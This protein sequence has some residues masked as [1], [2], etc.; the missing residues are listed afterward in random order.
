[1]KA[2]DIYQGTY[3]SVSK[4][5]TVPETREIID[6]GVDDDRMSENKNDRVIWIRF[7]ENGPKIRV[8]KTNA[9]NLAI[10]FGD[11]LE[12]WRGRK[13]Q[14]YRNRGVVRGQTAWLG[15]IEASKEELKKPGKK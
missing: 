8:N 6:I 2:S 13:V 15:V 14:I 4:W 5:P 9:Q 3:E 11:D 1:M 10:V 12:E 7:V